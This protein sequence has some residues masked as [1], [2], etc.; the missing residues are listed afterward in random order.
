M[1]IRIVDPKIKN[2]Q[3]IANSS[4]DHASQRIAPVKNSPINYT[5]GKKPMGF[6][7]SASKSEDEESRK[8]NLHK[9]L[10]FDE[11]GA[12]AAEPNLEIGAQDSSLFPKLETRGVCFYDIDWKAV[13]QST[14]RMHYQ[15]PKDNLQDYMLKDDS[16]L[17]DYERLEAEGWPLKN[18]LIRNGCIHKDGQ[19]N[20]NG[21]IR[22]LNGSIPVIDGEALAFALGDTNR[23]NVEDYRKLQD[24]I[25]GNVIELLLVGNTVSAFEYIEA[26]FPHIGM[27]YFQ[28]Q[29]D[30]FPLVLQP[31][32]LMKAPSYI[33]HPLK[34]IAGI[35]K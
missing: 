3:E 23:I 33:S 20:I 6:D 13:F 24:A 14:M 27:E 21:I 9:K 32:Y 19:P 26:V 12:L 15:G 31:Q 34:K 2:Q 8:R 7:I 11:S 4:W 10:N 22:A 5:P 25:L 18:Y 17:Y 30:Q 29:S 1:S 35:D 28:M 16:G